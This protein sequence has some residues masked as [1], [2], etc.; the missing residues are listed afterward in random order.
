MKLVRFIR[1]WY[2]TVK[3]L[4]KWDK[5]S[6][7]EVSFSKERLIKYSSCRPLF[8]IKQMNSAPLNAREKYHLILRCQKLRGLSEKNLAYSSFSNFFKYS[9]QRYRC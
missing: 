1:S 3:S 6:Q 7:G 2:E 5:S 4:D 9:S 8:E